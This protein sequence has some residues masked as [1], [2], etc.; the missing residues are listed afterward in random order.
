ML[1]RKQGEHVRGGIDAFLL[2][3]SFKHQHTYDNHQSH[4]DNHPELRNVTDMADIYV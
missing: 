2:Q 4:H 3:A 1:L